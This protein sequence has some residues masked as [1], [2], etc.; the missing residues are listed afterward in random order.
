MHLSLRSLT[1]NVLDGIQ[2]LQGV[3]QLIVRPQEATL[4]KGWQW[5]DSESCFGKNNTGEECCIQLK[6]ED[7]KITAIKTIISG[8]SL[9]YFIKDQVIER[10]FLPKTFAS[11][12]E[13][14]DAILKMDGCV[15]CNGCSSQSLLRID[16]F[17]E[18]FLKNEIWRS[19][20]CEKVVQEGCNPLCSQCKNL[21]SR[22]F[23]KLSRMERLRERKIG[24][25]DRKLELAMRK[26]NRRDAEIEVTH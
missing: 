13:L 25:R 17:A 23:V 1:I 26:I 4:P 3:A 6:F 22:M 2:T 20:Q 7:G 19:V 10:H 5:A 15:K 11:I 12:E 8:N 14:N 18:G 9:D 21:K 16:S 24:K